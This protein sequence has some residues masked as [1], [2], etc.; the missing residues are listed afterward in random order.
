MEFNVIITSFRGEQWELL[1]ALKD[2]GTFKK[3]SFRDVLI[4]YV[5]DIQKFLEEIDK[6]LPLSLSRVVIL[7]EIFEFQD[8]D[9]LIKTLKQKVKAY[10]DVI[11]KYNSF[12]V[13]VERRGLKGKLNSRELEKKLGGIIYEQT[14]VKVD[15]K[16]PEIELVIEILDNVC[17]LGL[18]D[19]KLRK[20]YPFIRSK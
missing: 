12:R 11:K 6:D 1:R 3:T 7:K 13:T 19:A 18:I 14:K 17:G 2:K 16:N 9:S 8:A 20:K 10:A 5:E 15:L 4:G